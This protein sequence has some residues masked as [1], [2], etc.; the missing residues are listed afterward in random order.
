M[1]RRMVRSS[2]ADAGGARTR[3][4]ADARWNEDAAGRRGDA[5]FEADGAT[6]RMREEDKHFESCVIL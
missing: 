1:K 3:G 6:D 5:D 2:S 4:R